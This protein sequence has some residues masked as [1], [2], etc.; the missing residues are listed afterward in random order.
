MDVEAV[1]NGVLKRLG[2]THIACFTENDSSTSM[3]AHYADC[4]TGFIVEYNSYDLAERCKNIKE[5]KEPAICRQG[6]FTIPV[7]PVN[8]SNVKIDIS[9]IIA[10]AYVAILVLNITGRPVDGAFGWELVD[11]LADL[12]IVCWKKK[13]W[14]L[15]KEWRMIKFCNPGDTSGPDH[16]LMKK[17]KA[18]SVC[19]LGRTSS[20]NKDFMK[21]ICKEK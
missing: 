14:E 18:S 21:E 9:R 16:I 17:A 12:K 11:Y 8:Y 1:L 6:G 10:C 19:I 4:S 13:D 7:F 3:E 15:E 5:Y 2:S 20:Y